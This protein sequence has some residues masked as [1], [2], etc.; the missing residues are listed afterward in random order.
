MDPAHW[1][2]P[3]SFARQMEILKELGARVI[4]LR[5]LEEYIDPEKAYRYTRDEG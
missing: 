4:A 1:P 5:D 3:I 2:G